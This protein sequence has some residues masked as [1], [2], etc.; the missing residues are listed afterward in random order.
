MRISCFLDSNAT[1]N[2]YCSFIA[3]ET[4]HDKHCALHNTLLAQHSGHIELLTYLPWFILS[5][6]IV[7][8]KPQLIIASKIKKTMI[9][10][11]IHKQKMFFLF[12]LV[13]IE[14]T[15]YVSHIVLSRLFPN[16]VKAINVWAM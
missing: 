5:V 4:R 8:P 10:L 2:S 11:V 15:E 1:D 12:F 9:F 13:L 7:A 6:I 3:D 14:T 16:L